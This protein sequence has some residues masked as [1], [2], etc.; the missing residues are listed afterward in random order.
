MYVYLREYVNLIEIVHN[1]RKILFK[2]I[3]RRD[4]KRNK[5]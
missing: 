3:N 2:E 4:K 1:Y 5:V